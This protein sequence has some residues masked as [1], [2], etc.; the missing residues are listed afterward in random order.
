M[1]EILSIISA[2]DKRRNL[3]LLLNGGPKEWD[4]I[5]KQLRVTS[6]G[7][8]PQIKILEEEGLVER[9]SRTFSLTPMGKVLTAHMEPL[10]RT[11]D[12][13]DK[14]KKFWQEHAIGALAEEL[15]IDIK[16][17]GNYQI[18]ETSNEQIFDLGVFFDGI[19]G[20]KTLKGIS[21]IVHP[22]YPDFFLDLAK[23]GTKSSLIFTPAVFRL[24]KEKHSGMLRQWLSLD[25]TELFVSRE[26]IRFSYVVTDAYFS[27]SFFCNSGVFDSI[28]DVTSR[29]QSALA[30]GRKIFSYYQKR[31]ERV[32]SIP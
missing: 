29:D 10:I 23:N 12:V 20:S 4:E 3:L 8:L 19:S 27:I 31:S 11:M 21:H 22:R 6:T 32:E 28:N 18:I 9:N 17:I 13:F 1:S 15:L 5:K 2:S 25:T 24:M 26:D 14:N 30:F 7:M 16:E